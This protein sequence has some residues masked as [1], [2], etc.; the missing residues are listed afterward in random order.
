MDPLVLL[1]QA[2]QHAFSSAI[3]VRLVR[4]HDEA[5]GRAMPLERL[6]Q[7]LGLHREGAGVVVLLAVHQQDRA[8]DPVSQEVA[9]RRPGKSV[10]H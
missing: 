5:A 9:L 3:A 6:V 1:V 2:V 7:P 4:Q 10:W 8:L